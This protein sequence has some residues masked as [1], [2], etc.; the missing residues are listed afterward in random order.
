MSNEQDDA[1][2]GKVKRAM[3][4]VALVFTVIIGGIAV[5]AW[6]AGDPSDLEMQYEGFD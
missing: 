5:A 3:M 2:S 1:A 6:F 4:I